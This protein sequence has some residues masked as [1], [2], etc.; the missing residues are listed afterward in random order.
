MF[1]WLPLVA[2]VALAALLGLILRWRASFRPP[3]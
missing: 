1:I 2:V 3:G